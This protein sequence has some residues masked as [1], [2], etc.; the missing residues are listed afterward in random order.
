MAKKPADDGGYNPTFLGQNFRIKFPVLN[1]DQKNDLLK[2]QSN[3]F[4][5]DYIHY[6]SVMS[7]SRRLA[8]FTAVNIDGDTWQD[9]SRKG[10]WGDDP[11]IAATDQLGRTL[12]SAKKS[13]FDK[14]HLVRREDPEWG[15]KN[16]SIKA[17]ENTFWFPNAAP[18]HQKLN[19][20]IWAELEANILHLG[21]DEQNLKVN[22][23]TGPVLVETD[24][25]FVTKVAGK[26]IQIPNLFWK[27]VVWTKSN[28][29][30]YAVGFLMSQEKFLIE[31]G[32]IKKPLVINKKKLGKLKDEDIFEHLE[33]KDGKTYQVKIEKIEKLTGLKFDWQGVVRPFKKV[34]AAPISGT[35]LPP[36]KKQV[37][38]SGMKRTM[39]LKGLTL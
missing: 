33:F 10:D 17:G 39:R 7:K 38:Q 14:G 3:K 24:G 13:D 32:I 4:R 18:Q 9:N 11:R 36:S 12:Y 5:L 15:D 37:A 8:F 22:V 30:A 23:F 6:T 34:E 2:F 35:T 28:G 26:D 29:K 19:R 25:T 27:I 31:G 21:A 1:D 20:K 16:L